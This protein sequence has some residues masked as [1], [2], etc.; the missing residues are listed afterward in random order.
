MGSIGKNLADTFPVN[1]GLHFVQPQPKIFSPNI[2]DFLTFETIMLL[3][4][5]LPPERIDVLKNRSIRFSQPIAF[6][7]PFEFKPVIESTLSIDEVQDEIDKNFD[8]LIQ[9]KNR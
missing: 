4:K 5:Y 1:V 8:K 2:Q 6:N 3:Y 7:D 9:S